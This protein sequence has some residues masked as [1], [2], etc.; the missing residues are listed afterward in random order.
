MRLQLPL[1]Q[2]Y[3]R[4]ELSRRRLLVAE[5]PMEQQKA[6]VAAYTEERGVAESD[7]KEIVKRIAK[8]EGLFAEQLVRHVS[9]TEPPDDEVP[10]KLVVSNAFN[11]TY[12]IQI[13]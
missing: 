13:S 11:H 10:R 1:G 8:Y 12:T 6:L 3:A 9:G 2:D 7:A 4:M 5:S